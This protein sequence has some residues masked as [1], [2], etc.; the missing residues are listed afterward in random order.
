[1]TS[2]TLC[3]ACM[4]DMCGKCVATKEDCY[5]KEENHFKDETE[6]EVEDEEEDEDD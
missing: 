6:D 2:D 3:K 1:M 5:C 4:I